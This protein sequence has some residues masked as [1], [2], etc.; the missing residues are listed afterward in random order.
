VGIGF[1]LGR[2]CTREMVEEEPATKLEAL[3]LRLRTG[4]GLP[5]G[6]GVRGRRLPRPA[7][8]SGVR[9]GPAVRLRGRLGVGLE[10]DT[11]TGAVTG[12]EP[13]VGAEIRFLVGSGGRPRLTPVWGF[14]MGVVG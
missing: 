13:Q 6:R 11:Q 1:G 14:P 2:G 7:A 8:R 4:H 5:W 12:P 3:M 9:V 10:P